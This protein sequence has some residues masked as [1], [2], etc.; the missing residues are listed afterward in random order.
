MW[1]ENWPAIRLFCR[2]QRCWR[3]APFG[4]WIGLDWAQLRARM[5]PHGQDE[6]DAQAE[7]LD[8]IEDEVLDVMASA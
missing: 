3:V 1:P 6:V 8:V 7:R 5:G 4:G 2:I